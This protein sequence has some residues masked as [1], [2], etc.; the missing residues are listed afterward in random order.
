MDKR[1]QKVC[2]P[3]LFNLSVMSAIFKFLM[4]FLMTATQLT[5]LCV[6]GCFMRHPWLLPILAAPW[7]FPY[8]TVKTF[9]QMT[10]N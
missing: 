8:Y 1:K 3:R 7:G 5:Q 6:P 10:T 4:C 9:L 2:L